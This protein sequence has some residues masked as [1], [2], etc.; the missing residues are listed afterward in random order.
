LENPNL[1]KV[2]E[3]I[4]KKIV[5]TS[6]VED[7]RLTDSHFK[8]VNIMPNPATGIM[9]EIA[10]VAAARTSFLGESTTIE[11]DKKLFQ[12]LYK[13]QHVSPS[14][15][16]EI[17]FELFTED[18][19]SIRELVEDQRWKVYILRA[20]NGP[21]FIRIDLNNLV[22]YFK[23]SVSDR[24][25]NPIKMFLQQVLEIAYPWTAELLNIKST[26]E[27][28]YGTTIPAKRYMMDDG[29][30]DRWVEIHEN[31]ATD[32]SLSELICQYLPD[33]EIYTPEE[34]IEFMFLSG[35]LRPLSLFSV[36][37]ALRA[38]VLVLWQLVRH[39]SG[40]FNFQSGRYMAFGE[41]DLYLPN[42]WR[43]QSISNK[44]G[45]SDEELTPGDFSDLLL[46]LIDSENVALG[47]FASESYKD[48]G[49]HYGEVEG[50][51]KLLAEYYAL[52]HEI[53]QNMLNQGA[54]K[55]EARL[56]LPAWASLYTAVVK[57]DLMF[58]MRFLRLRT[59]SDAQLEIRNYAEMI[60][61]AWESS[62]PI[63]ARLAKKHHFLGS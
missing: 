60:Y 36:K 46:G 19:G 10:I 21:I 7:G 8:L 40:S 20:V 58:F 14:E 49:E 47:S 1:A 34:N 6:A 43:K 31:T 50:Y 57:F 5:V 44:Q 45:S 54:A 29:Y 12:Y 26:N 2:N 16:S 51:S 56:F 41:D 33:K 42:K 27:V 37:F 28:S 25:T 63:T 11:R 3:L 32:E 13:H 22:A 62:M 18:E 17:S 24:K 23:Q 15:M 61:H 38:P 39:R 52:G 30:G 55:E 35:D 59:A 48:V 9:P 4:G 53:Y